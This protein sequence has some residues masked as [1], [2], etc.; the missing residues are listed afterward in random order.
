MS[1]CRNRFIEAPETR[2]PVSN[3]LW[4]SLSTTAK[5]RRPRK[6][7]IDATLATYP[8][9]NTSAASRP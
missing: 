3:E 1:L 9:E 8:V 2:T 7:A 5:S 4:I 6:P